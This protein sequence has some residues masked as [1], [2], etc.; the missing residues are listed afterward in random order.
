[1]RIS[2]QFHGNIHHIRIFGHE[3]PGDVSV[4]HADA[5]LV[6]KTID[7]KFGDRTT[8]HV[9]SYSPVGSWN[10]G[11]NCERC[12][13]RP[14]NDMFVNRTWTDSTFSESASG[15]EVP[16]IV[17]TASVGFNGTAVYVLCALARSKS[18]P[19]GNSDMR[20]FIDGHLAGTFSRE[21]PG[22]PG[23]EYNVTVFS[24]ANLLPTEHIITIQNG[25]SGGPPSLMLLDAIVYTQENGE[26]E[27]GSPSSST[28]STTGLA[29]STI[30]AIVLGG[31]SGLD[32]RRAAFVKH[33]SISIVDARE[34]RGSE[35]TCTADIECLLRKLAP[36]LRSFA[37]ADMRPNSVLQLFDPCHPLLPPTLTKLQT[38]T[39]SYLDETQFALFLSYHIPPAYALSP[40]ALPSLHIL[41]AYSLDTIFRNLSGHRNLTHLRLGS[42]QGL[43]PNVASDLQKYASQLTGVA[44]FAC[45]LQHP[46]V[47][48]LA[49][50][51]PNLERLDVRI[52]APQNIDYLMGD[53]SGVHVWPGCCSEGGKLKNLKVLRVTSTSKVY[54]DAFVP[55]AFA[56]FPT[57]HL[58]EL[59]YLSHLDRHIASY[60]YGGRRRVDF[61]DSILSAGNLFYRFGNAP[62]MPGLVKWHCREIDEW[63]SDWRDVEVLAK[64]VEGGRYK[65]RPAIQQ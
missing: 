31:I 63:V 4:R 35:A 58:L 2:H 37:L 13:A 42:S 15:R 10:D 48:Q 46:E 65:E 19:Y 30:V 8:K 22:T 18:T 60:H 14:D 5:V 44:T 39:R 23:Y 6:N 32:D 11:T 61:R 54:S 34:F 29:T 53:G 25:H 64:A 26:L 50:M 47:S 16:G 33:L 52:V 9:I 40:Q 27:P 38:M 45:S 1:M 21:A 28:I 43:D 3:Y 57:L 56:H 59:P 41:A 51:L 62:G 20:F 12:S 36:N 17:P 49:A 55:W 7:D 24:I